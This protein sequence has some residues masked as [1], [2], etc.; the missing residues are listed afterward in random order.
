M[1][2]G[3]TFSVELPHDRRRRATTDGDGHRG[4]PTNG[5][6]ARTD[7]LCR[8]RVA[9]DARVGNQRGRRAKP[10]TLAR[11]F[12]ESHAQLTSGFVSGARMSV[13]HVCHASSGNLGAR[14]ASDV[15]CA[16]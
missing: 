10:S 9:T 8:D 13:L 11:Q 4:V 5:G 3:R 1:T 2:I 14:S 15:T 6:A 7:G 12:C 16:C